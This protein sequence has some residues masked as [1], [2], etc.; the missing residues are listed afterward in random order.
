MAGLPNL[1][2]QYKELRTSL[3]RT[4]D[5]M[6]PTDID[7]KFDF[8][9]VF[10]AW[11]IPDDKQREGV[12]EAGNKNIVFPDPKADP[13]KAENY[14]FGPSDEVMAAIHDAGAKV[15]YRIGRSWGCASRTT[16]RL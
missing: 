2:K 11:L 6:G 5:M 7:A 13:E 16:C 12:I 1:V 4:H 9:N 15:Y 10:L 8:K 14:N 3:V